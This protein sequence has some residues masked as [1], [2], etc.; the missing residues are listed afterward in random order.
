MPARPG[1]IG[2]LMEHGVGYLI[3]MPGEP[4]VYL[5][6]DTLLTDEIRAF[7]ARHQPDVRGPGWRAL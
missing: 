2:R 5:A 3:E 4:S 6:G 7:V 1:V